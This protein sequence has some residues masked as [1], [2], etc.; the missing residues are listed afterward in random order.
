MGLNIKNSATESA[1]R[2]LSTLTGEKLTVAVHNAVA[3]K[4]E[5]VKRGKGKQPLTEYLA[6]LGSLQAA[7]ASQPHKTEDA[8]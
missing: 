5:R 4:L 2:E 1:I 6:S 3:E 7:L 8:P